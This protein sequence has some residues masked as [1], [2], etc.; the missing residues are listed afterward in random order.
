MDTVGGCC[1]DAMQSTTNIRERICS[2]A[3]LSEEHERNT[4]YDVLTRSSDINRFCAMLGLQRS[5][6]Y[7]KYVEHPTPDKPSILGR[8]KQYVNPKSPKRQHLILLSNKLKSQWMTLRLV[9]CHELMHAKLREVKD[10]TGRRTTWFWEEALCECV[11]LRMNCSEGD[12]TYVGVQRFKA[13]Y[14]EFDSSRLA[15][16][17][18]ADSRVVEHFSAIAYTIA[19]YY[20]FRLLMEPD[21]SVFSN[22]M[23][24]V[25]EVL[26][27][28]PYGGD[29]DQDPIEQQPFEDIERKIQ[30]IKSE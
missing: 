5:N 3:Y 21:V 30:P 2:K 12:L 16:L 4:E 29:G 7:V 13:F 9:M 15:R 24:M 19:P 22:V 17:K 11:A 8:Y 14:E 26:S 1:L 20:L 10:Q 23:H 18:G 25:N 28:R 6:V 27:W